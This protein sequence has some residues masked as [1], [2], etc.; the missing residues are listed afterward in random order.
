M[1]SV[2]PPWQWFLALV[3]VDVRPRAVPF[4][5]DRVES[6][7]TVVSNLA[8]QPPAH[9]LASHVSE[10]AGDS[11]PMFPAQVVLLRLNTAVRSH[12]LVFDSRSAPVLLPSR[13]APSAMKP[14][15]SAPFAQKHAPSAPS[16][17]T[18]PFAPTTRQ[19]AAD[20]LAY[21]GMDLESLHH[22]SR[23][24]LSGQPL[25]RLQPTD[26]DPSYA[27]V[28]LHAGWVAYVLEL[29]RT[30]VQRLR[31]ATPVLLAADSR[32]NVFPAPPEEVPP[33]AIP[34]AIPQP[35]EAQ[36]TLV[37]HSMAEDAA[38]Y[39][40]AEETTAQETAEYAAAA[41]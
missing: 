7:T 39:A 21:A 11:D 16:A 17:P 19:P 32:G 12:T 4:A 3:S 24:Y 30:R 31:R 13:F 29:A 38:E 35:E 15:P 25:R 23:A 10:R 27:F 20:S 8:W 5:P 26:I 28:C 6:N 41:R 37:A 14:A 34:Q 36:E 18:A 33:Q 9:P 40:A 2:A 1:H 22:E